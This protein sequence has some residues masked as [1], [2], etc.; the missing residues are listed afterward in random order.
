MHHFVI[1]RMAIAWNPPENGPSPPGS[2]SNF[3][4]HHSLKKSIQLISLHYLK[5]PFKMAQ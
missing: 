2:G 5:S 4:H 1:R 3:G